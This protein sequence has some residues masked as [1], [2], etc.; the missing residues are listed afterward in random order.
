M[1]VVGHHAVPIGPWLT[2]TINTPTGTRRPNR[3]GDVVYFDPREVQTLTGGNGQ[4]VAGNFFFDPTPGATF[5]A[6]ASN[7][8]GNSAPFII[9]GPGRNNWDMSLFKNFR[10]NERFNIQFRTEAFNVW[11]HASFRSPNTNASAREYGTISDAGP[12]RL[13]QFGLKLL[14]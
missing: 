9:R 8:F 2:P 7:Q 12:P 5:V 6:P 1:A 11:N 3:V 4:S 10:L 14:F 13:I